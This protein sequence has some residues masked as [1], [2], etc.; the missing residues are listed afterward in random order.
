[1]VP[2]LRKEEILKS[3][4]KRDI[5]YIKD[6]AAELN[7][8]LSTVRR[9]VAA[10][11]QEGSVIVMRG[12]AVKYKAEDFDEPVVKKKLI[13]SEE[14]EIIARKAA[15]LVEDGDCVYVD[16]GTTTVGMLK[17]LQG[18]RITIVSS[19]TELLDNLP[20]KNAKCILLGGEVRDDLE[21]VLGALTEKMIS[22]M[23]FDKAFKIG[24]AHV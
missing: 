22:D 3:I 1:M 9:D 4:K 14:K 17:Y 7:I 10:L 20:V 8:S 2:E 13:H 5:S 6:L 12:G 19:S 16:S 15:A 23:Y 21:S 18:K 24:R 11:E